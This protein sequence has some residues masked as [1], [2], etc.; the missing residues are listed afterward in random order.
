MRIRGS[1]FEK[2]LG[3]GITVWM[4]LYQSGFSRQTES[5]DLAHF[6]ELAYVIVE[7]FRV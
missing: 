2:R 1:V 4:A 7:A 6:K 5:I 3:F